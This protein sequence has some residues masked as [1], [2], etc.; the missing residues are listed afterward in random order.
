MV[1]LT[2]D[3]HGGTES[4]ISI[5]NKFDM[6]E[7]DIL[8]ILGDAGYNYYL[9]WR[10]NYVKNKL[11]KLRPTIFCIHGNHECRPQNIG[12][13]KTKQWHDGT[14]WYEEKYPNLLFA[15]DGEVFDFDGKKCLVCGGAYSVDKERRIAFN[16]GWWADEQPSWAIRHY[17]EET[18]KEYKWKVDVVLTHTCPLKYEPI[19]AFMS[20]VDQSKVDKSTETWLDKIE[21]KLDY[22]AW[23]CG[24]YHIDKDI[25]KLHFMFNSVLT[26]E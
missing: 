17:T 25:D 24:H 9:D 14:V 7:D 22:G 16:Y 6:N 26:L 5:V 1:Y 4:V 23:Y 21:D 19:E 11:A 15:R 12:T 18:I 3:K 2:G 20:G 8:I 13:Y 10:D